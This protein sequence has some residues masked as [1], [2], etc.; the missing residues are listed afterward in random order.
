VTAA[1]PDFTITTQQKHYQHPG[2]DH[3]AFRNLL[4]WV[5]AS[6]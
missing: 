3:G 6:R 1:T 2:I 4:A 5:A